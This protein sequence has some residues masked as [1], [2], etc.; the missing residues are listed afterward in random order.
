MNS[1]VKIVLVDDHTLVRSSLANLI[2]DFDNCRV[3]FEA[4]NGI[5][6][7]RQVKLNTVP[8]LVIL[9]LNMEEMDG[10]ETA[11]WL[12]TNLP[13]VRI[14]MLSMYS[15][16]MSLLRML[17]IGVKG[18]LRK[19]VHIS[20]L[21]TAIEAIMNSGYY[22]SYDVA[23]KIMNL[24]RKSEEPFERANKSVISDSELQ[25]L[26]LAC[27]EDTYKEIA[28]KMKMNPRGIDNLRDHLFTKLDVKSRIGLA[29]YAVR[30]GLVTI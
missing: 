4:C 2:N 7:I 30:Q 17:R 14:L 6:F 24:F 27:T 21:K 8:D 9:D 16:E 13:D 3:I 26:K 28:Q 1:P 19:D 5:D 11:K 20:E 15:T 29:M 18:F 12:F 22:Y 10:Y 25:F 23:G